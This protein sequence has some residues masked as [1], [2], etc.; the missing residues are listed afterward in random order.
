MSYGVHFCKIDNWRVLS[1]T[2]AG[3]A[4]G[5]AR[6]SNAT[7]SYDYLAWLIMLPVIAVR[8]AAYVL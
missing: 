4:H 7:P 1:V 8:V 2:E 3:E 5:Q 6:T